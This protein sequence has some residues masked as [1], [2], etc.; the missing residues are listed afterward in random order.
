MLS[1]TSPPIF[2]QVEAHL[3]KRDE[4]LKCI[5][6]AHRCCFLGYWYSLQGKTWW[7]SGVFQRDKNNGGLENSK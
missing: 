6:D 7:K 3:S 5:T 4:L 2:S 1:R